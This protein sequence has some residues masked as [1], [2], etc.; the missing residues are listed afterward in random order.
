MREQRDHSVIN[1]KVFGNDRPPSPA[2]VHVT[3]ETLRS[4]LRW[5]N[6]FV[7]DLIA[8]LAR[9]GFCRSRR[10]LTKSARQLP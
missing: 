2:S 5:A 9:G 1:R 10:G 6:F 7:C 8:R 3:A 4:I